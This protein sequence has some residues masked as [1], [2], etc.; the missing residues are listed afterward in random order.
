MYT[1]LI[2]LGGMLVTFP[3]QDTQNPTYEGQTLEEQITR[4]K[5]EME[6]MG[7]TTEQKGMYKPMVSNLLYR[8]ISPWSNLYYSSKTGIGEAIKEKTQE[9]IFNMFRDREGLDKEELNGFWQPVEDAWHLYL[10]LPQENGTFGISDYRPSKGTENKYYF[11]INGYWAYLANDHYDGKPKEMIRRIVEEYELFK[12]NNPEKKFHVADYYGVMSD[13]S[14]EKGK[15]SK[16]EY[17]SVYDRWDLDRAPIEIGKP[18]EIYD[19]IHFNSETF[20][21]LDALEPSRR[22]LRV[23]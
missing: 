10:G 7:I 19:R 4:A 12:K 22:T 21:P 15:D 8:G 1:K 23:Q 2:V 13:Y 3:M 9:F 20:E 16:G 17:I 14:I 18:I 5:R 6:T 11:K